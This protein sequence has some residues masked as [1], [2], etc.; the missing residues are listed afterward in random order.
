MPLLFKKRK[1]SN[2]HHIVSSTNLS[3][4]SFLQFKRSFKRVKKNFKI[5]CGKL[6]FKSIIVR[7]L[8]TTV[9]EMEKENRLLI[10]HF[11]DGFIKYTWYPNLE[12][13]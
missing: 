6:F 8:L 7:L 1:G 10:F 12:I 11:F 2:F 4:L 13:S 3:D 5:F 9:L